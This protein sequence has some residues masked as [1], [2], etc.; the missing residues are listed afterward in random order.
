MTLALQ[1]EIESMSDEY[2]SHVLHLEQRIRDASQKVVDLENRLRTSKNILNNK[3]SQI[4]I[5]A[6]AMTQMIQRKLSADIKT[7]HFLTKRIKQSQEKISMEK[8]KAAKLSQKS[9]I[10]KIKLITQKEYVK[11]LEKRLKAIS[12]RYGGK[13][14]DLNN[15]KKSLENLLKKDEK[16]RNDAKEMEE[17]LKI[18]ETKTKPEKNETKAMIQLY[19]KVMEAKNQNTQ[20]MEEL[21]EK[22][23][24]VANYEGQEARTK[25]KE[26]QDLKRKISKKIE[27]IQVERRKEIEVVERL[28]KELESEKIEEFADKEKIKEMTSEIDKRRNEATFKGKKIEALTKKIATLKATL[29]A[30]IERIERE[31]F[32]KAFKKVAK[33]VMI[34][35]EACQTSAKD[36]RNQRWL[37]R[38]VL[39]IDLREKMEKEIDTKMQEYKQLVK[40]LYA[41][42]RKNDM[43]TKRK[44]KRTRMWKDDMFKEKAYL[45]RKIIELEGLAEK[46]KARCS[47]IRGKNERRYAFKAY[48]EIVKK[49][50]KEKRKFERIVEKIRASQDQTIGHIARVVENVGKEN[51]RMDNEK[52]QLRRQ[53][54]LY[55]ERIKEKIVETDV[56]MEIAQKAQ[57]KLRMAK[58]ETE[59]KEKER[60]AKLKA[61]QDDIAAVKKEIAAAKKGKT[62]LDG[63]K[64]QGLESKLDALKKEKRSLEAMGKSKSLFE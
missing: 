27:K 41:F 23:W 34:G 48:S 39:N 22:M 54:E 43:L 59:R 49:I 61:V 18:I 52:N 25:R 28:R 38:K 29:E 1:E 15:Q 20:K 14:D 50:A 62:D 5:E 44:E 64:V 6:S 3:T 37:L 51:I 40:E 10:Y 19:H 33:Q 12:A 63:L 57:K 53:I 16:C 36:I 45:K 60:L 7:Q 47:G 35:K 4:Q 58:E 9:G 11:Y 24:E 2:Q 30:D 8:L 42:E 21:H 17:V 46:R 32:E 55:S 31:R 13:V 56:Q 26:F